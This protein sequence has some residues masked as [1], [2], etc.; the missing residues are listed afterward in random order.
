MMSIST[1]WL[2][3]L[4]LALF[5]GATFLFLN[6]QS[7]NG[8]SSDAQG[9]TAADMSRLANQYCLACHNDSLATADLSLQGLDFADTAQ[10]AETM[11]KMVKKLRAHMMPP[12]NM[13]RPPFETYEIM[14]AWLESELDRAWAAAPNPGRVTPLHRM[15]RY[16][17]NNSVNDLLGLNVDVM[18]LLPGDPTA[19]GSFDNI[20]ESLPFSTA[21]MERYMSVARQ[22]TRLATGLPANPSITTYEIPLYLNQDWR[23]NED[24]PFGS[25]GGA[26]ASHYFPASGEYQIK[27]QLQRNYQDYVKGLGWEQELEIRLDGRLLQRFSIGGD[28]PGTPAPLSFTGTGEPGSIDW[29]TYILTEEASGLEVRVPVTAG[30]HQV[31]A[32]YVRQQV[33]RE[34]IPQPVQGGRLN[35]NSEVYLDYQKVHAIEIGG[36][37][38]TS[39]SVTAIDSPS[40]RLIFSCT[41]RQQSEEAACATEILTRMGRQAYRRPLD[42]KDKDLLLGFFNRGREQGASFEAGIQFALEF[43]LSDPDFLIRS[44]DHPQQLTAGEVFAISD[45]ELASRLSFFL[46]S[47]GPDEIL[48]ELAEQNQLSN[49][50]I[51]Q[52]QVRRM[53]ADD[54]GVTTLVED[55]AA[56]WLNLR[57]LDEVQI[58]TVIFPE[59]DM[60]LIEGFEMETQLFIAETLKKDA[61]VME[62]LDANYSFLNERL[63]RHYGVEGIYGSRFRKAEFPDKSQR[64]GL[65]AHGSLLS[66]TSYPGRTSPVLRGKWLLDN[67]LGTPPPPPPP[68]V[69]ILPDASPGEVPT[70]IRERLARHRQDP[71][72]STCHTVIDPL[73]FALENF[74]VIGAWRDFDEIGNPVDPEGNYPGGVEFAGFADLRD[75]MSRRPEQFSHTLVEKLMTYAL[76][77]RV[78]YYDQPTIRAIV[79]QAS[80]DDYSWSSLVMG[81]VNSPA[82]TTS[83]AALQAAERRAERTGPEQLASRAN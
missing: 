64:G 21:H 72:C 3:S 4:T 32:S 44:Y 62:L 57:R 28:A 59:Y 5:V 25:R 6:F 52:Q 83:G 75:W 14:T 68:N 16:E 78:E 12:S 15:N 37:Y 39:T 55:F 76:G 74:D 42:S 8:A 27:V 17:Y 66:V 40:R 70:S 34:G 26:A 38:N 47:S 13:P 22:L 56:Q 82:F 1:A 43:M 30:P 33:E 53:L 81:V 19:D 50:A 11:E 63:A 61:S 60:S 77:R 54:R 35:A 29:E 69:P 79:R 67:L 65:M 49:P 31:T 45:L 80:E 41:P 9:F 48:L 46:W 36:P 20:A 58:N 24:M 2:K 71:V 51:Y 7:A 23:Q 10:H 73:G 18:D